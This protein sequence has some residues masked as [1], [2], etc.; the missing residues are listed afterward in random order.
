MEWISEYQVII[1]SLVIIIGWF[2]NNEFNRRHEI[3]KSRLT[4]RLETLHSF[5]PMFISLT[6]SNQPFQDD[7]HLN[8][9]IQTAFINIQLYGEP[10]ELNLFLKFKD[11]LERQDNQKISKY[12]NELMSL[13]K[14]QLRNELK[15]SQMDYE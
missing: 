12:L 2:T 11:A 1:S 3:A 8:Q 15:L 6:K 14:I 7:K 13:I 9:K 10:K 5:I 4:Y